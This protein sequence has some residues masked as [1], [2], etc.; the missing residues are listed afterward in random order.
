MW[1]CQSV[2]KLLVLV[3]LGRDAV[4]GKPGKPTGKMCKTKKKMKSDPRQ[5]STRS[6]LTDDGT[7]V[8]L[9]WFCGLRSF[10]PLVTIISKLLSVEV[11][12]KLLLYTAWKIKRYSLLK[13]VS[14]QLALW[15]WTQGE[16][17]CLFNFKGPTF[18]LWLHCQIAW[19]EESK[20][21]NRLLVTSLSHALIGDWLKCQLRSI[22]SGHFDS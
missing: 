16:A 5:S 20:I 12:I 8:W 11:T 19:R 14:F 22:F 2:N 10:S 7:F 13:L 9:L 15:N 21:T 3:C 4:I 6:L 18:K 17:T 1:H